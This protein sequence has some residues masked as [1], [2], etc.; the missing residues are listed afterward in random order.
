MQKDVT[1]RLPPNRAYDENSLRKALGLCKTDR[2]VII[3]RSVDARR[4]DVMIDLVCR[5]NPDAPVAESIELK[6]ADP[7]KG[8]VII[9]GS[10]PAGLF[11]AMNLLEQGIRP[12]VLERG[13]DVHARRVDIAKISTADIV[14]SNSNYSFGEGGAGTY[15][16][17]KLYTRSK[18]RG[19]NS[20]VLGT[21]VKYGASETILCDAHPHIGTDKLPKIIEAMRNDIISH[22][23]QVLFQ[24]QATD[25]VIR[26]GRCCGVVA[27]S[28]VDG[29]ELSFDGPVILAIGNA[30]RDTFR[31]VVER[32]VAT[33]AKSLAMGV[34]LEHPQHLID[35]IQYHNPAGRGEYLPAAE[36]SF[37]TQVNVDGRQMGVYSF[38][39]CPGGFVVPAASDVNQVVVNGMSPSNRGSKWANSGMVVEF[40]TSILGDEEYVKNHPLAMMD[41]Q[42]ALEKKTYDAANG[43]Q[44][45]PAQRMTDFMAHRTSQSLNSSSYAPG[46]TNTDLWEVL[47]DFACKALHDGF[48]TFGRYARGFMTSEATMIGTETRTSG[49]VRIVRDNES[50]QSVS[51]ADL[52]PCG[53]GAGYA[54]G[55]V[56]AAVD[57][58]RCA[59][60]I[61]NRLV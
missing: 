53:E 22:G 46:L 31:M 35:Q 36:Y 30:A 42:I 9:V 15:S 60:M 57:G 61:A 27:K 12:I 11:A 37:T 52:Y 58:M 41:L 5:I 8:Q 44:K 7:S 40:P 24:T 26:D 16:D 18:K 33:E 50:L 45:A 1:L 32:G 2:Y 20:K 59:Q 28:L 10:G 47:P 48:D 3:R 55:I 4:R 17:G 21:F 43:M 25:L 51:T 49:P 34:R 39:M 29:C 13:K 14:D 19:E 38:C 54:G 56:S 23:G 6:D